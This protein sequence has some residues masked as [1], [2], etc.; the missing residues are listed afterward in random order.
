MRPGSACHG[1]QGDLTEYATLE[2]RSLPVQYK[3]QRPTPISSVAE[4]VRETFDRDV[5]VA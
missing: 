3:E 1:H 2:Y 5:G 4:S